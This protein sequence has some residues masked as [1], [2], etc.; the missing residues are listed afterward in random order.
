M[1]VYMRKNQRFTPSSIGDL[2]GVDDS[3]DYLQDPDQLRDKLPQ[4]YRMINKVLLTLFDDTWEII[5]SREEDRVKEAT[6]IKPPQYECGVQV[7]V[8]V[9]TSLEVQT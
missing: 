5:S 9:G 2:T 4:P 1:P 3:L 7:Q 6:R 8:S